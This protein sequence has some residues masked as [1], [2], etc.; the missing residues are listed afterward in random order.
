MSYRPYRHDEAGQLSVDAN[1]VP[2][3]ALP[4]AGIETYAEGDPVSPGQTPGRNE[5]RVMRST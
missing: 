4:K 3:V 2:A 1:G 5:I